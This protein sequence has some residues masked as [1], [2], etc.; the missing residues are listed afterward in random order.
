[1]TDTFQNLEG[2]TLNE[3]FEKQHLAEPMKCFNWING[4][5]VDREAKILDFGAGRG[6]LG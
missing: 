3:S 5:L 1:M 6:H 2:V 4:N